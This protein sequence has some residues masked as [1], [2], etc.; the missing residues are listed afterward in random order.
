MTTQR[1]TIPAFIGLLLCAAVPVFLYESMYEGVIMGRNRWG[2]QYIFLIA[3]GAVICLLIA[4]SIRK[5]LKGG[6]AWLFALPAV[7]AV[8]IAI[9]LFWITSASGQISIIKQGYLDNIRK[10]TYGGC[11][12][13]QYSGKCP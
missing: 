4:N 3:A 13:C 1:P 7:S 8:I 9:R 11:S 6:W 2:W 5:S 12:A 10:A